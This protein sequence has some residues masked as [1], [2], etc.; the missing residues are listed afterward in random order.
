MT[1]VL[2][3]RQ[4]G[5][6]VKVDANGHTQYA[7]GGEDIVCAALSAVIQTAL[8]GLLRV[9]GIDVKYAIADAGGNLTMELPQGLSETDRLKADIILD[10]MCASVADLCKTWSD[11][12]ELT[13][14]D[15]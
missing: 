7:A 6:I 10:T 5:H 9:A 3:E 2:V 14:R 13:I 15:L 11:F 8:L 12:I 1:K 4:S